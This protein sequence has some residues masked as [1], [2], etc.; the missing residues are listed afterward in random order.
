MGRRLQFSLGR[1]MGAIGIFAIGLWMVRAALDTERIEIAA[2]A[3]I[4]LPIVLGAAV[5]KLF[6]AAGSGAASVAW[7]YW[8]LAFA[9]VGM[10]A[11]G[12]MVSQLVKWIW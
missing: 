1:L 2:A 11:V 6:G 4:A 7:A 8:L 10:A 3:A 9:L 5:G 12:A